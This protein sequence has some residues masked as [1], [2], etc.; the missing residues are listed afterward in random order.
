[1]ILAWIIISVSVVIKTIK[2]LVSAVY[3]WCCSCRAGRALL[4]SSGS[5]YLCSAHN[6]NQQC[7]LCNSHSAP[8][9]PYSGTAPCQT[10]IRL[11]SHCSCTLRVGG[12][13]GERSREE[14][15]GERGKRSHRRQRGKKKD[16]RNRWSGETHKG[17]IYASERLCVPGL[18]H[19]L[20]SRC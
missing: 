10:R 18:D 20:E 3:R 7:C 19:N 5:S 15:F 1:M 16:G 14:R 2:I 4:Q 6:G 17:Y 8:R 13:K 11:I 9:C 12:R